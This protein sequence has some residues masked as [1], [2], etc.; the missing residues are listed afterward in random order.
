MQTLKTAHLWI[1]ESICSAYPIP[2]KGDILVKARKC[3]LHFSDFSL[4]LS[5]LPVGCFSVFVLVRIRFA[6]VYTYLRKCIKDPRFSHYDHGL[7]IRLGAFYQAPLNSKAN[8]DS[9]RTQVQFVQCFN[10]TLFHHSSFSLLY[11]L[12]ILPML[13]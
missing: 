8:E 2:Q 13:K 9:S 1:Y 5:L 7:S 10:Q 12:L 3:F 4:S 11:F 6:F